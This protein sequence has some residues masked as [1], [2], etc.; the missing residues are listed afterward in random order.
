[1]ADGGYTLSIKL[2]QR[3]Q[4]PAYELQLPIE[5]RLQGDKN[6]HRKTIRLT[7]KDDVITLYFN[8]PPQALTIDP[9]FDVF[10][11]LQ[12]DERPASL[13]RLFGAKK[14]LLVMP[15]E[16][17]K[18]QMQAWKK[19]AESWSSRYKNVTLAFDKEIE[20]VPEDASLWILGWNNALLKDRQHHFTI[21]YPV[22]A[23]ET[24][25]QSLSGNKASIDRQQLDAE[26]HAVVLLDAD[27]NRTAQGFIGAQDPEVIASLARKLPHYSSYG[28]L[29]FKLPE[30][31]NIIKQRLPALNSPMTWKSGQ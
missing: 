20:S 27:S 18:A 29:V 6:I 28:Q 8:K 21:R 12:D 7:S 15:A 3:Q 22:S 13:G 1:Q 11:L 5:V 10:R 17:S 16:A 24:F 2:I 23:T 14:Q 25:S 30:V 4:G 31:K 26:K 9:G 19:L